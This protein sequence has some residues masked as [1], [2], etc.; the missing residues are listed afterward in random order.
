M[1]IKINIK[2]FECEE[3]EHLNY[4]SEN[5]TISK[6]IENIAFKIEEIE[7]FKNP[8]FRLDAEE[9]ECCGVSE[10]NEDIYIDL[11]LIDNKEIFDFFKTPDNSLGFHAITSGIFEEE[12]Q[13]FIARKHRVFVMVNEKQLSNH[14]KEER[15][16]H[17]V[18]ESLIAITSAC[19][20]KTNLLP[21]STK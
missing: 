4:K 15:D 13:D 9:A 5:T 17:K 21:L 20:T 16:N 12:D 8:I 2:K 1:S 6:L 19:K 11:I 18:D 7:E 3:E 14:I 10:V